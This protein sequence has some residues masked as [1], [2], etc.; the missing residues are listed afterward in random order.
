[1]VF[2]FAARQR[3]APAQVKMSEKSNEIGAIP[4]LPDMMEIEGAVITID[5]MGCQRAIAKKIRD[6]KT[7]YIIALKGNQGTLR[8]DVEVF[9][10]EQKAMFSKIGRLAGMR[11]SIATTDATK[12]EN[13]P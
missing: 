9:A 12:S 8:E 1:M 10:A 7:G 13:T 2:A 3:L 11:P 5:A 6:K 4:A